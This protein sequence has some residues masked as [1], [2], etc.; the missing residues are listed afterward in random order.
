MAAARAARPRPPGL[1]LTVLAQ[2]LA[3]HRVGAAVE[4]AGRSVDLAGFGG[5]GEGADGQLRRAPHPHREQPARHQHPDDLGQRRLQFG[6]VEMHQRAHGPDGVEGV[7]VERQVGRRRDVRVQPRSPGDLDHAGGQVHACVRE[8]CSGDR[9]AV[10]ARA[11]ADL[12]H[13]APPLLGEPD[14]ELLLRGGAPRRDGPA[15]PV[16]G[17]RVVVGQEVRAARFLVEGGSV[18]FAVEFTPRILG[19]S[20]AIGV[21]NPLAVSVAAHRIDDVTKDPFA[22][23]PF[24]VEEPPDDAAFL[25]EVGDPAPPPSARNTPEAQA[26][27]L[28]MLRGL[29][30]EDAA[31]RRGGGPAGCAEAQARADAGARAGDRRPH[32]SP[33][34]RR[35]GSAYR[36]PPPRR[37]RRCARRQRPRSASWSAATRR[38]CGTTSGRPSRR[39]S[40]FH[41]RA[42]VVQ[43]TGWGKSAVYFVATKLLRARGAG[44]TVIVSP[45]LALMRNQIS[46]A[47]RAGIRAVTINSANMTEWDEV[48]ASIC[49]RRGRRAA[50]ARRSG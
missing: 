4:V 50:R 11:A 32:R 43:R 44:P 13:R 29:L 30:D 34:V 19:I 35:A 15:G 24:N 10:A 46:A 49:A 5:I 8:T 38:G 9:L 33:T 6:V 27:K 45:L 12:Q 39:S 36:S 31:R 3:D 1:D 42:L 22:D 48:H 40:P 21:D 47:A 26:A 7:V 23:L 20:G 14:Q 41:R 18:A 2:A 37:A 28:Q 16:R 17:L 25:T